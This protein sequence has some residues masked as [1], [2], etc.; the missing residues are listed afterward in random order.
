MNTTNMPKENKTVHEE[1]SY[2]YE[3]WIGNQNFFCKGKCVT[4][5][6]GGV[7]QSVAIFC[8][9][10]A[11]CIYYGAFATFLA[12]EVSIVLP[13][14]WTVLYACLVISYFFASCTDP[15]I[16]PHRKFFMITP[17]AI[18]RKQDA[19]IYLEKDIPH[20]Y[21]P[22]DNYGESLQGSCDRKFCKTCKIYRP[23]RAYHCQECN[24]CCEVRDHHCPFV[25]NCIGKRNY[26]Y[27][28]MFLV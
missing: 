25:G 16:I 4:G 17:G 26:R 15:G 1:P 21:L 13:I 6:C 20:K 9:I 7:K 24:A 27:F 10:A 28:A 11:A 22:K 2:I 18:K 8:M 12:K 14:F 3:Y 19:Y 5:P 23:P